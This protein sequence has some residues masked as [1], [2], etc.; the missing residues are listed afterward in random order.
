M[1]LSI[2]IQQRYNEM[3]K[4]IGPAVLLEFPLS[5]YLNFFEHCNPVSPYTCFPGTLS[6]WFSQI[7]T[8]AGRDTLDTLHRAAALKLMLQSLERLEFQPYSLCTQKNIVSWFGDFFWRLCNDSTPVNVTSDLYQKDI[9]IAALNLLPSSSICHFERSGL[10]RAFTKRGGIK[11]LIQSAHLLWQLRGKRTHLFELHME[12]RRFSPHFLAD[13]W[14]NLYRDISAE[15][16]N[17]PEIAGLFAKAWFWDPAVGEISKNM[18]YLHDIPQ[19]G[20]ALFFYNGPDSDSTKNALKNTKRK[21][22]FESGDYAPS[23]YMMIWKR[24]E[25]LSWSNMA[26]ARV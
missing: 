24:K 7:R 10:S 13:G 15:M 4:S 1:R 20:G 19:Q 2:Q 23:S 14:T 6:Q 17:Q 22:L 26:Q 5:H 18:R 9:Q 3:E 21:R 16:E 25:L 11:Q 8:S 12:E